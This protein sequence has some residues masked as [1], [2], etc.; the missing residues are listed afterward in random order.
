MA[1]MVVVPAVGDTLALG[2][3]AKPIAG[4]VTDGSMLDEAAHGA[5]PLEMEGA[6]DHAAATGNPHDTNLAE[7]MDVLFTDLAAYHIIGWD[8]TKFINR[9]PDV[10]M[11]PSTAGWT[12]RSAGTTW[13]G[14]GLLTNDGTY[15]TISSLS[16]DRVMLS[17]SSKHLVSMSAG[18]TTQVMHG[19]AGGPPSWGAVT[20]SDLSLTDVTTGNVST[21]QHGFAPR[22]SNVA[23]QFL[24]GQ[25]NYSTPAGT[26]SAF[27]SQSFSAQTTVTVTHNFGA[28]PVVQIIDGSNAVLI[29]QS[30]THNSVNDFTVVFSVSSS[31]NILATLGSPQLNTYVAAND[32]YS[33]TASDY[34]VNVTA[35]GKTATLE[36]ASEL[37]GKI[38]IIKNTSAGDITVASAKNIDGAASWTL[39]SLDSITAYY[40]GTTWAII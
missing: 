21:T 38:L 26:A 34:I 5:T 24:D 11:P 6:V 36:A 13:V 23:T 20:E 31:G 27:K 28:Y 25:G 9:A 32:N 33:T 29:P 2:T 16:Q 39:A 19:N 12:L 3:S 15:I 22:L 8:G 7:L 35:S 1:D 4:I 17:D 37:A 40:T 14:S 30:I 18:T 10:P